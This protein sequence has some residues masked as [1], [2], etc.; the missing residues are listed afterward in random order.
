MSK[1]CLILIVIFGL[2][3]TNCIT[4]SNREN[5]ENIIQSNMNYLLQSSKFNAPPTNY[6]DDFYDQIEIN[7]NETEAKFMGQKGTLYFSANYDKN[8]SEIFLDDLE[9]KTSIDLKVNIGKEE[10]SSTCRLWKSKE[11]PLIVICKF[12][13]SIPAGKH[14]LRIYNIFYKFYNQIYLNI[15]FDVSSTIEIFNEHFPFIY[16][17]GQIINYEESKEIYELNFKVDSFNNEIL[18]LRGNAFN[19]ILLDK[20]KR[21]GNKITYKVEKQKLEE[22]MSHIGQNLVITYDNDILGNY[23][24]PYLGPI[25]INYKN[26]EKENIYIGI[27]KLLDKE[28][29][30]NGYI[31]YETNITSMPNF[32]ST[33]IN[34]NTSQR[35]V[36]G[37]FKKY[38]QKPLLL[39][40][41]HHEIGKY[42]FRKN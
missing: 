25:T 28:K 30:F 11:S 38:S 21:N 13:D 12:K 3:S 9:E 29:E 36:S 27:V 26:I 41:H 2:L 8:K 7:I 18:T 37:F 33:F 1:K 6:K 16:S 20:Y 42:F 23:T 10:Y 24:F 34:F 4:M 35:E 14:N 22:I 17:D 5:K 19:L 39:F 31:A 32:I 40:I 15:K